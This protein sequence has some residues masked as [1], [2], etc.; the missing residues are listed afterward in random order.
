MITIKTYLKVAVLF[1]T[2]T[3]IQAQCE[4]FKS[5]IS[6]VQQ[7]MTQFSQLSDS[8][9]TA[10]EIASFDASIST[11]RKNTK[12]AML[13]IGQAVN[14]AD[15]AVILASEAQYDSQTCGLEDAMSYTIDAER[16]TIDSRDFSTEAFENV[17]N[18]AKANN[19]GNLQYYMRKAQR[20]MKEAQSSADSAVYAAD[21]AHYSCSHDVAHLSFDR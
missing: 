9:S 15:E 21:N 14:A 11:A 17:K 3:Y 20:L 19:L 12:T 18:A 1:F 6:D 5:E 10:V 16:H 7:Y 8:L 13:L 2:S 4:V